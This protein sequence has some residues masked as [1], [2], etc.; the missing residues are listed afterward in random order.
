MPPRTNAPLYSCLQDGAGWEAL[1]ELFMAMLP[2]LDKGGATQQSAF[3]LAA[4]HNTC[5]SAASCVSL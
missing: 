4:L 5:V 1:Q 2:A 3:R